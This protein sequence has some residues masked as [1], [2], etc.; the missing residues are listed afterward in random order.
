ML[1]KL[2]D[3]Q[4]QTLTKLTSKKRLKSYRRVMDGHERPALDLYVL[5]SQLSSLLHGYFRQIEVVL[6]EQINKA[7]TATYGRYWFRIDEDGSTPAGLGNTCRDMVKKARNELNREAGKAWS[8]SMHGISP[9]KMV[10][11]LMMG[12][13][14][15]LLATPG[16]ADHSSTIWSAGVDQIF[17]PPHISGSALWEQHDAMTICQRLTWA[18]NRVNHCESVVFGFPQK[19]MRHDEKQLRLSPNLILENCRSLAGRFSPELEQW[20]RSSHTADEILKHPLVETAWLQTEA[21]KDVL[22]ENSAPEGLWP[23]I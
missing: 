16:D 13:W 20:L 11:E 17:N 22:T 2:T 12:F 6:R 3:A 4:C 14:A 7:L 21:R 1:T 15:K 9:D 10:A 18:R 8:Q 23:L 19:G 5:D